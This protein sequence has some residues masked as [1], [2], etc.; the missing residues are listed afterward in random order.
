MPVIFLNALT[1]AVYDLKPTL[2]AIAF[3]VK[4]P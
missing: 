3:I 4:L 2:S 1:N